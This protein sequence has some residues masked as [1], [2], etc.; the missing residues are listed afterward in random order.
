MPYEQLSETTRRNPFY[1]CFEVV[2]GSV[3]NDLTRIAGVESLC[4]GVAGHNAM[5]LV[6]KV[7]G[8]PLV[9]PVADCKTEVIMK[10][11]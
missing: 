5:P 4:C 2:D 8:G 6:R 7:M 10:G 3:L 1:K 11:Q 9:C